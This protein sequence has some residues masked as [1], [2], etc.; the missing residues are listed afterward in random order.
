MLRKS[1]P[2][3]IA[4]LLFP[5]MALE[6][7]EL[8]SE[9][10]RFRNN[11]LSFLREEG[12]T[13][14]TNSD[15]NLVVFEKGGET[16]YVFIKGSTPLYISVSMDEIKYPGEPNMTAMMFAVETANRLTDYVKSTIYM[17][18]EGT[19]QVDFAIEMPCHSAEEF[20]Y[21]LNTCLNALKETRATYLENYNE[22]SG[23]LPDVI[24]AL[25]NGEFGD[26]SSV[27]SSSPIKITEVK[28]ANVNNDS[29]VF[30]ADYGEPIYASNSRYLKPKLIV[31]CSSPG[32]YTIA[33][34][35]YDSAGN[36]KRNT[37]TSP[38]G[39][40][41]Q[42]KINLTQGTNTVTMGGWGSNT[43]GFWK[44][45]TCRFEFFYDGDLLYTQNVP[46]L[47][48]SASASAA[49]SSSSSKP[50]SIKKR[51]SNSASSSSL[52]FTYNRCD[53][54]NSPAGGGDLTHQ[55]EGAKFTTSNT[56]FISPWLYLTALKDGK[57][58]LEYKLIG[59]DGDMMRQIYSTDNYTWEGEV[60]LNKNTSIY[61][62]MGLYGPYNYDRQWRKGEYTFEFYLNHKLF[63]KHS[64]TIK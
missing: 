62:I 26:M 9:A 39:Y 30:M 36:L 32:E 34:R 23:Q 52:P 10:V 37:S 14:D 4:L 27:G 53:I 55:S 29:S 57:Y 13:P 56:G 12:Y 41:Y 38:E 42:Q 46:V 49:S 63:A 20:R 19:V 6:A 31:N 17:P 8:S 18:D 21:V 44:E 59:P 50:T 3:L 47:G 15:G 22:L 61:V 33:Y 25:S 58:P 7:V 2:L 45:G 35:L 43:D 54:I 16:Y 48:A 5:L 64:F 60:D 24:T 11:L 51:G 28:V 1:L 40:T